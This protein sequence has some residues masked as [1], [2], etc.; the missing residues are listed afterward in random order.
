[1]RS[2]QTFLDIVFLRS[3]HFVGLLIPFKLI[4]CL[5]LTLFRERFTWNPCVLCF[6]SVIIRSSGCFFLFLSSSFLLC[7]RSNKTQRRQNLV[8]AFQIHAI[9]FS[10]RSRRLEVVGT[11]KNGRARR[12]HASLPRAR[13]FSLSPATSQRL[14]RRLHF[15]IHFFPPPT[16][17]K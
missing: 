8:I 14:L 9:L 16:R 2:S 13:P 12:R 6:R 7:Q 10:L 1:M 11:R 3:S 4:S 17:L 15:V 5:N